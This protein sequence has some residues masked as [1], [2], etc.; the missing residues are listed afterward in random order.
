M[1]D[2]YVRVHRASGSRLEL[3]PMADAIAR[4]GVAGIRTHRSWWV[5]VSAV[6]AIERDGRNMRL[7][8]DG[9]LTVP[10]ARNRVAAVRAVPALSGLFPAAMPDGERSA[11]A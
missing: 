10:V 8:L 3:M 2:H 7:R 4:Y 11:T 6:R 9:G 1:E 5:A